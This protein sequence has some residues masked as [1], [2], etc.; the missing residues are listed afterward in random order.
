[1][2][3]YALLLILFCQINWSFAQNAMYFKFNNLTSGRYGN[4]RIYWCILGYDKDNQLVYVDRNGNLVKARVDMN[5]IRKNDRL[6][7]NICY[8]L[9]QQSL[10]YVPDLVSGRMYISYGEQVYITFNMAADGRVGYA[11]QI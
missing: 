11:G 9:E 2:K 1:M 3:L 4:N 8:T 5:T 6:C 10:V 7:A